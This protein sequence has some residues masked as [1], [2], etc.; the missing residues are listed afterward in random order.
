M[1]RS[2]ATPT[3]SFSSIFKVESENVPVPTNLFNSLTLILTLITS[4]TVTYRGHVLSF[5]SDTF[6]FG[7]VTHIPWARRYLNGSH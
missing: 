1:Y 4:P 5:N 3:K 7:L 6:G 2:I